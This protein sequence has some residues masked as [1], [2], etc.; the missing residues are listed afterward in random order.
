MFKPLTILPLL[1]ISVSAHN[2]HQLCFNGSITSSSFQGTGDLCPLLP[3]IFK[4]SSI[5]YT[6]SHNVTLTSI[7]NLPEL[8]P[9]SFPD[10]LLYGMT[11]SMFT[12]ILAIA[13]EFKINQR[14]SF[15]GND[16]IAA[17]YIPLSMIIST[18]LLSWFLYGPDEYLQ[19]GILSSFKYIWE[20][21]KSWVLESQ[22]DELRKLPFNGWV[23]HT[24][25]D[26][27]QGI[28]EVSFDW[29]IRGKDGLIYLFNPEYK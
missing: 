23:N 13:F 27:L 19:K 24:G 26:G 1:I 29:A 14:G 28:V 11:Y 4:S 10:F 25:V 2:V 12:G 20:F 3:N 7:T 21:L 16:Y 6:S 8:Y 15:L 17:I 22:F 9:H 18:Q 5:E